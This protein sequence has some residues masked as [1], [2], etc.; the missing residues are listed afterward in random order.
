M[1]RMCKGGALMFDVHMIESEALMVGR[2]KG[3]LD[4]EAAQ[5]IVDFI[6]V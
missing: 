4:A 6:E 3:I 1:T 2:V 5:G